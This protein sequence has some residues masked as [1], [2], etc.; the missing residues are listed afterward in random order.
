MSSS[1][2]ACSSTRMSSAMGARVRQL[3]FGVS[4]S[5]ACSAPTDEKSSAE[6][7]HCSTLI[8]S[9]EWLSSACASSVSNGGHLSVVPGVAVW[10]GEA[11]WAGGDDTL[12]GVGHF[13]MHT[14]HFP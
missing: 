14:C 6:L 3:C 5:E 12:C 10:G 1:R 9:N 8:G 4:A 11:G 7:R 2:A 13:H